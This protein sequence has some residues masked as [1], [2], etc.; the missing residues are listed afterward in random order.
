MIPNADSVGIN[1]GINIRMCVIF[2]YFMQFVKRRLKKLLKCQS[3]KHGQN[4]WEKL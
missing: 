1:V 2:S 3:Y 4:I